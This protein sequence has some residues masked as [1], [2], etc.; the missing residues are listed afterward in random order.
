[1]A[2]CYVHSEEL[3]DTSAPFWESLPFLVLKDACYKDLVYETLRF[4]LS[5][6][7][8]GIDKVLGVVL[9]GIKPFV[10]TKEAES[11]PFEADMTNEQ[12]EII[13][14]IFGEIEFQNIP[15]YAQ[16]ENGMGT[17]KGL[18]GDLLLPGLP[19]PPR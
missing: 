15:S 7:K 18:T 14:K 12:G 1:M 4:R 10:T 2:H 9:L 8:I 3:H 17:D 5:H 16:L 13:C 6:A 19:L 11:T